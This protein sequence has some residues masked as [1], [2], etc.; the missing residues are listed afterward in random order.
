LLFSTFFMIS[1]QPMLLFVADAFPKVTEI[2]MTLKLKRP[3][4][5][6]RIILLM[7]C[8]V[9]GSFLFY[10]GNFMSFSPKLSAYPWSTRVIYIF[11]AP[12]TCYIIS[13]ICVALS[14]TIVTGWITHL[15]DICKSKPPENEEVA[16]AKNC[17]LLYGKIEQS[18]GPLML[19]MFSW[20]Q[21][22]WIFSLFLSITLPIGS[23]IGDTAA[24]ACTSIGFLMI[25]LFFLLGTITICF[26]CE[27]LHRSLA[28]VIDTLEDMPAAGEDKEVAKLIKS[29]EKVG[30]LTGCGLFKIQRSTLTSMVST[31]IT[32]LII[33][34]QF[35]L[36]FL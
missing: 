23:H 15:M 18:L 3:K 34:V 1:C 13:I 7:F 2:S 26:L 36:S 25:S 6:K 31:S 32:Y 24:L 12:F 28:N 5:M 19:F 29:L 20:T 4:S 16:W 9:V 33:L 14:F 11:V 17:L 10:V 27:D 30:P 35:K 21:V 22:M 8:A